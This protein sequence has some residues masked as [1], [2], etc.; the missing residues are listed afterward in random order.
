MPATVPTFKKICLHCGQEFVAYN[1]RTDYCSERCSKLAYKE[2]KRKE[3]LKETTLEVRETER[4][5]LLDKNWL[6]I[7][8]AARL[9]QMS[10]TTLYKIVT[11]NGIELRRFTARTIRIA[12]EDLERVSTNRETLINNTVRK[13]EENLGN[14][15]TK[16]QVM[17]RYDISDSG[18]YQAL[19]KRGVKSHMIGTVGFYDK[20]EM[21]RIFHNIEHEGITEWYT[22]DQLIA[23]TG[24]RLESIC[25]YCAS[26][27]IPR[28]RDKTGKALV[29]KVH[30]DR[31]KGNNIDKDAFYTTDQ[32]TDKYQLSRNH[33]Y[34]VLKE[35]QVARIK[36]G[37]TSYFD[38]ETID[39]IFAYRLSKIQ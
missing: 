2:R 19:K 3:R 30:W 4:I 14:W 23:A 11:A 22:F 12:R 18:F 25:D 9:L 24:M 13:Q 7:S 36:I 34:T 10:R 17:E 27:R 1:S 26:H 21:H 28:K 15:M 5:A 6:T 39:T 38:R 31:A 20:D 8:D 29:S 35:K 16:K 32:I 33:L 37:C